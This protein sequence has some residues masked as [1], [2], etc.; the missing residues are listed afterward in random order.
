MIRTFLSAALLVSL[1]GAANT[2]AMKTN[3]IEDT[4]CLYALDAQMHRNYHQASDFFGELYKR[5]SKK[6]YLYQSIRML[7]YAN[8][9]KALG[10]V[11]RS[12]LAKSPNDEMLKRFEV[13]ALLKE[14]NYAEAS[15][16]SLILSESGEKGSDHLLHAEA[17]LKL[18]DYRGAVSALTKAYNL[19]YEDSTA[20][21]IALIRYA[22]L[23]EKKEAIAFLKEHIG[24]HGNSVLIGKRLG[25]LYAD[26][27]AL[28]DAARIYTQTYEGFHDMSSADEA[29]KIYLYQKD[30]SKLTALLEKSG[31]NDPLLLELY[32]RVKEFDKASKLA[33]TLYERED[34]PIYLAQSSVYKYEA[35]PDRNNPA[36]LA[37]VVEGLKKAS[38]DID[39]PLYLNY[40]GYLM[41]DHNLDI[42]EGM[43][44]VRRALEKQPDS[45]YYID[46]L[47]WGKYKLGE[48]DEAM[49]LIKQVEAMVGNSEEEVNEHL[50]A[51]ESCKTKEKH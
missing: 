41:I 34:N 13:I 25:S 42:N 48:C 29:V 38:E 31:N 30:F 12:A 45:A 28:E 27:G 43:K 3:M 18:G 40:L 47:A 37:S 24:A 11:V 50:K 8:D 10:Q 35:S 19:S 15:Q 20:E 2:A 5:T 4:F 49:S 6:E 51:I 9:S 23:D 44:Y 1:A 36:L 46:S 32:V 16:K 14:G 17:R 26:S 7:E 21:R 22:H 39:E 33:H